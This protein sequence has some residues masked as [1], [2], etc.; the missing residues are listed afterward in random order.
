MCSLH[1]WLEQW[2]H[3][4]RVEAKSPTVEFFGCLKGNEYDL[5]NVSTVEQLTFN[6]LVALS[7]HGREDC[8]FGCVC[9]RLQDS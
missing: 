3:N 6:Q 1:S 2:N 7:N 4:P 8:P 5:V 9:M